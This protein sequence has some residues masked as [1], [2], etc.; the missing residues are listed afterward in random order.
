MRKTLFIAV[1]V[2][3]AAS[4]FI[5]LKR[6]PNNP[7]T[8][9]KL[10]F[11]IGKGSWVSTTKEKDE[12]N[13]YYTKKHELEIYSPV[14]HID[15]IYHSMAGPTSFYAVELDKGAKPHLLWITDYSIEVTNKRATEIMAKDF[16][17]HNN[18]DFD[19]KPYFQSFHIDERVNG[20]NSRYATLTEGQ[21]NIKLPE[22]FG[23]PIFSNDNMLIH[24]QALNHN[25]FPV[26]MD[27][28]HCITIGY[29]KDEELKKPLIPLYKRTVHISVPVDTTKHSLD[30]SCAIGQDCV[31]APASHTFIRGGEDGKS[32]A[33]HWLLKIGRDTFRS[34]VT[35]KMGLTANTTVHLINVHLHPYAET[36]S[37]RDIT[38]N[39]IVYTSHVKSYTSKTGLDSIEYYSNPTGVMLYKDHQY[40]LVC[41]TNNTSGKVQ[42]MMAVMILYMR[43]SELEANIA[44][45]KN[46]GI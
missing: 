1:I 45:M 16:M 18:L 19:V 14:L 39:S 37:L 9:L 20:S 35:E 11:T 4:S 22:G 5:V 33:S 10:L 43:D 46:K 40:E 32:Y 38:A 3:I 41:I 6:F 28:R 29:V 44:K 30:E 21:A 12:Q 17:C 23:I 13:P 27:V 2:C 36:L 15:T 42:D 31:A 24:T 7:V 25:I 34:N 8:H 26:S